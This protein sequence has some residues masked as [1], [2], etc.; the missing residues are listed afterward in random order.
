MK[1][2][3]KELYFSGLSAV[4]PSKL[5]KENIKILFEEIEKAKGKKAVL[6][7]IGKAG[8][9]MAKG[10]MEELKDYVKNGIV[11]TK[12]GHLDLKEKIFKNL[13]ILEAGHP[14]PDKNGL[15][16]TKEILKR[17]EE[18]KESS[19]FLIMISGGTSS[20]FVYPKEEI[21]LREKIRTT[22][23]LLKRGANIFELNC[24][25]KHLS[26]VK[27]GNLLKFL[28]PAPTISFIISDVVGDKLDVIGSGPTTPDET[29]FIE[30]MEI[31]KKYK[32]EKEISK[33]V[34]NLIKK[35]VEGK[36][37][38][39]PK[40]NDKIF[41]NV[42][43]ILIGNNSI[44]LKEIQ[45]KAEERGIFSKILLK[46]IKGEAKEVGKYLAKIAIEEKKNKK[47][48]APLLLIF[49]GET[50]V[51]VKGNGIGGRAQEVAL[52]FAKEISGLEGIFFLSAGSDGTDGPTDAAGAIVDN[53]TIKEGEKSGLKAK[54][55]LENNDSYI[56]FKKINSLFI[57]GPTG[58]NVMDFYLILIK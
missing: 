52:S 43:N 46:D 55:F 48:E 23:I 26:K 19:I 44:A 56:F 32:I 34:L 51:N 45:K 25:R 36:I 8:Y 9:K 38:E 31:L 22:E 40:K 17:I 41:K 53:N 33:N 30:A 16:G 42:K 15:K 7:S 39:N 28:Y 14:V 35:G 21:S 20:L 5:V 13:K 29:T 27:G 37:E 54:E 1:E 49:G 47:I 18:E 11:L 10:A 4:E 58:T 57:T 3:L 50:T 24:I 12:Y 6:F 2:I